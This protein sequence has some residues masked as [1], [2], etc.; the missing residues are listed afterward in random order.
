[1]DTTESPNPNRVLT[2][3]RFSDLEPSISEPPSTP[4]LAPDK[5]SSLCATSHRNSS[6]ILFSSQTS[7]VASLHLFL[8]LVMG[9][10]D[11]P[12]RELSSKYTILHKTFY[13]DL[14]KFLSPCYLL[15]HGCKSRCEENRGGRS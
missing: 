11:S 6:L 4:P 9:I 13:R 2:N 12:T 7:P 8:I 14:I 3:N 15:G 1:M 5:N 10:I